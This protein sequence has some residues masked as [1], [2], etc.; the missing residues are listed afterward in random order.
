M[1]NKWKTRTQRTR[2]AENMKQTHKKKQKK[3]AFYLFF[4]LFHLISLLVISFIQTIALEL[5]V[6]KR[7][8]HLF[9]KSSQLAHST[10]GNIPFPGVHK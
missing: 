9:P 7:L 8:S 3:L 4:M 10:P 5:T 2:L 1:F 6:L